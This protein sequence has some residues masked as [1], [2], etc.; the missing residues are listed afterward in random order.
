MAKQDIPASATFY[1]DADMRL[2]HGMGA[3]MIWEATLRHP[4]QFHDDDSEQGCWL[5]AGAVFYVPVGQM[6]T[7]LKLARLMGARYAEQYPREDYTG[8]LQ[9]VDDL[10]VGEEIPF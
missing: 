8:P 10:P 2:V 7:T 9:T 4:V 5:P 1:V 3:D 6:E